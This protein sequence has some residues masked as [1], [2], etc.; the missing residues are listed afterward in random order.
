MALRD[1]KHV[2]DRSIRI[3]AEGKTAAE[4]F[5]LEK[6]PGRFNWIRPRAGPIAFPG[7][8]PDPKQRQQ[9]VSASEYCQN[10][11]TGANLMLI[12]STLFGYGD[13]NVRVSFGRKNAATLFAAWDDAM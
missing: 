13:G 8:L 11:E 3:I 9:C 4:Q 10:L 5:F 1:R 7:L 6:Q 2:L 12:P